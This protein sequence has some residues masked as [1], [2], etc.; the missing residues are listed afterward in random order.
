MVHCISNFSSTSI[1]LCLNGALY[2]QFQYYRYPF[3]YYWCSN[4]NSI[5]LCIITVSVIYVVLVHCISDFNS[6]HLCIITV[7][8]IYVLLVHC[9][10][11]FNSIHLCIITVSVISIYVLLVHCIIYVLSVHCVSNFNVF[12]LQG[13]ALKPLWLT[14][15]TSTTDKSSIS[16]HVACAWASIH[17][18]CFIFSE[19]Y[20]T[21]IDWW[22]LVTNYHFSFI[23]VR[24][25]TFY[26]KL[27]KDV[28]IGASLSEPHTS[29]TALRTCVCMFACLLAC[30][31][32]YTVNF[33][34]SASAVKF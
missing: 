1:H 12:V 29:V 26:C 24:P 16:Q 22:K 2:Q 4:F 20:F 18:F 3:M 6:I 21:L 33:L 13:T 19:I 23:E 17:K 7:S 34:M 9:I 27:E 14:P 5:H 11:D 32:P 25:N 10:S 31:Q 8:V 28:I 15:L 30:L